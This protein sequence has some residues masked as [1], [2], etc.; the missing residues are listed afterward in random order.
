M[1]RSALVLALLAAASLA[2]CQSGQPQGSCCSAGFPAPD[3]ELVWAS[4]R[5]ALEA[6]GFAVDHDAS[7]S[8][9]GT[10]VSRWKVRLAP[11]SGQGFREKA[12]VNIKPVEGRSTYYTVDTQVVRQ[13]ND[14]LTD[15]SNPIA[16]EWDRSERNTTLEQLINRRVEMGFV[17]GTVST[18]FRQR[19]GM[20]SDPG[21]GGRMGELE[22]SPVQGEDIPFVS[23][24]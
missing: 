6:Q 3:S 8:D 23:G 5:D 15:P 13:Y 14:N 10:M 11:F 22:T 21:P 7:S 19:H 1:N 4:A 2:A 18:D 24:R 16:A 12:T 17:P 9:R 20:P